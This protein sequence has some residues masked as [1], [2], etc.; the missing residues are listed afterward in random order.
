MRTRFYARIEE[1]N[2]LTPYDRGY[3]LALRDIH[4]TVEL[5]GHGDYENH[6]AKAAVMMASFYVSL[7]LADFRRVHFQTKQ[8][9]HLCHIHKTKTDAAN[10]REYIR[11][12]NKTALFN[13]YLAG[14]KRGR[15]IVRLHSN[16]MNYEP[17][18][19]AVRAVCSQL[20]QY[21]QTLVSD[22]YLSIF[23]LR[24]RKFV[25]L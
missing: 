14:F 19:I 2:T 11:S 10:F 17:A 13:G 16:E 4:K 5:L 1:L 25:L 18:R 22:N 15:K 9:R 21:E 24:K 8:I 12:Y 20:Y 6:S 3:R 7:D 23:E